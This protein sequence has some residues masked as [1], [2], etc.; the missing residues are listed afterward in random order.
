MFGDIEPIRFGIGLCVGVE[1]EHDIGRIHFA[2]LYTN[3]TLPALVQDAGGKLSEF[4][5]CL[6]VLAGQRELHLRAGHE[7]SRLCLHLRGCRHDLPGRLGGG[8]RL[9]TRADQ[10]AK[11]T[12]K[13]H[14]S[15]Y[16]AQSC[17]HATCSSRTDSSIFR[18]I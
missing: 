9:Q 18:S 6:V 1:L 12:G 8:N 5:Q 4:T 7:A 10:C 17:C 15:R 16:P 14:R 2:A 3:L 11:R 13:H